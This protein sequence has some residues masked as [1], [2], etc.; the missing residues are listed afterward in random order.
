MNLAILSIFLYLFAVI[1]FFDTNKGLF[2]GHNA[3][4]LG[5]QLL[6][7]FVIVLWTALWTFIVFQS[8]HKL[9]LLRISIDEE[10]EG[11]DCVEHGGRAYHITND[12]ESNEESN[13]VSTLEQTT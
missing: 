3:D 1:S 7:V 5:E 9:N 8:L 10:K 4:L 2:Y 12:I 13:T 11:I 6:G